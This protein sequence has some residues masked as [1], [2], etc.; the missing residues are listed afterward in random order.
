MC[1]ADIKSAPAV[2]ILTPRSKSNLEKWLNPWQILFLSSSVQ[3]PGWSIWQSV[4]SVSTSCKA[5]SDSGAPPP[6]SPILLVSARSGPQPPSGGEGTEIGWR[7]GLLGGLRKQAAPRRGQSPFSLLL[8]QP[9][10][11]ESID[12]AVLW[13]TLLHV[14][15]V[16]QAEV[17]AE[18]KKPCSS[19][20]WSLLRSCGFLH[21]V[22]SW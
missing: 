3:G 8:L 16:Q 4:G 15:K 21:P 14:P 13:T 20:P 1:F 11:Q 22:V 10:P 12:T 7:S 2:V 5:S 9:A 18:V 6:S 17:L 19:L